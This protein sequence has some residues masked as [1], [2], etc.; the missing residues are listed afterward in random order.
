VELGRTGV[1]SVGLRLG[2]P[3]EVAEAAAELDELGYG[4][5]WIGA[6]SP[7]GLE[8]RLRLLLGATRSL[9][10]ATGIASIWTH[11]AET[12]AAIAARLEAEFPGRFL[13]GL[14]VSHEPL[15]QQA[16]FAYD[17]PL[18]AMRRYL[19]ELDA[20]ERPVPEDRRI[21]A[22]LAPKMLELARD[23]SLGSFP[24][25]VPPAHT[26]WA[27]EHL[28]AGATLAVDVKVVPDTDAAAARAAGRAAMSV[29]LKLPNYLD[30]LRRS[31][32]AEEDLVEGGSDRLVDDLV[33][34]GDLETIDAKLEEHRDAGASHLVLDPATDEPLPRELW[35]RL[36]PLT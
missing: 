35:R 7:D 2:E 15:V 9:V 16:G 17:K 31:G 28:G 23:R 10:V 6:A 20:A 32:F 36:A 29:H 34:W 21:L 22:A 27:R 8:E 5:I 30:N 12:T 14:G 4:A 19:D 18:S 25:L 1:R 13:L 11:Q 3:G 33:A 26:A 24:F